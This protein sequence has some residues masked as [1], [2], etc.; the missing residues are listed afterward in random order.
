MSAGMCADFSLHDK[1]DGNPHAHIMLTMRPLTPGG[2]WGAKCRKEYLT[3]RRGQRIPDGKGG[4]KSRRVDVTDWNEKDKAEQWR[5]AWAEY[6]NRALE[7]TGHRER[8]DHRSYKR[9]GK[10]QLPTVHMG[11]AATRME[12]RGIATDKG[13][14][15]RQI[16][17]DNKLLKEI[18]ARVTRLYN[19][20][21]AEAAKPQGKESVM[22]QLWQTRQDMRKPAT[23]TGKV[24]AL[25]ESAALFNFLQS[26][27]ITSMRELHEKVSAMN[28]A[29]YDQRGEIRTTER[30]IAVLTERLEMWAQYEQ[31]KGIRRQFDG[32]KPGKRE[33]FRERHG[34]ELA[35]F[36]TA[37]R[38]LQDLKAT[39]EAIT[40]RQWRAEADTLTAKK[41]VL[42]QDMRAMREGIKAVE[43]LRKAAEQLS[44]TEQSKHK[45]E[46]DR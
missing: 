44:K 45:E 42:Y 36:D 11:V 24:K 27:G 10:E 16:A 38:Y 40:P 31:H 30:R 25:K 7:Q 15:N 5:A 14:V 32:L 29:Y 28:S 34:A 39:G 23:R 21:K 19:W 4:Y 1:G 12:R 8:I 46:P 41:D 6:A 20:T 3:D 26:N 9:Q 37:A 35:L 2:E 18:K 43:Q 17:A 13:N 22:A 33:K